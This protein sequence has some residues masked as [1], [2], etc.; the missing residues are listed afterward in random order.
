MA[1]SAAEPRKA[2][3]RLTVP[4][5]HDFVA[6]SRLTTVQLDGTQSRGTPGPAEAGDVLPVSGPHQL[7][8]QPGPGA[9]ARSEGRELLREEGG[10]RACTRVRR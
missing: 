6:A 8:V 2:L 7:R 1:V 4:V 9:R 10:D 5:L 3:T